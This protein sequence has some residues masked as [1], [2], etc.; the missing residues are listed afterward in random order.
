[1][2]T[3]RRK[4]LITLMTKTKKEMIM[5]TIAEMFTLITM[6]MKVNWRTESTFYL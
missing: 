1:M 4:R 2:R 3:A 5:M 6:M